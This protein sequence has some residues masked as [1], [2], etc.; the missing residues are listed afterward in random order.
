MKQG[1]YHFFSLAFR[2]DVQGLEHTP[3]TGPLIIASNHI[4]MFEGPLIFS[5]IPRDPLSPLIKAEFEEWL[6]SRLFFR[7]LDPIYITRGEVD[8][9]ALRKSLKRLRANGALRLS[10]WR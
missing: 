9:Q 2:V 8:R 7:T 4:N 3:L 1:F 10:L 6:P 5:R